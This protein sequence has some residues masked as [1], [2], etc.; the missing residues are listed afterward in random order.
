MRHKWNLALVL[1]LNHQQSHISEIT[2]MEEALQLQSSS[3][4]LSTYMYIGEELKILGFITVAVEYRLQEKRLMLLVV[5][6]LGP[7]LMG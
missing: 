5:A 7:S 3:M 1:S 2:V 4:H 6:D